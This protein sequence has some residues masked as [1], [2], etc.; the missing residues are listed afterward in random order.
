MADKR[1]FKGK[2]IWDF[3]DCRAVC[4]RYNLFTHGDNL[5]YDRF[6]KMVEGNT[7]FEELMFT[8]WLCSDR[9]DIQEVKDIFYKEFLP[10]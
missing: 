9:E 5:Q 1:K 4:I 2:R 8:V 6:F 3:W 10:R 7:T